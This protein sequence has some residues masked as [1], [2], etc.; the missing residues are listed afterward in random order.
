VPGRK[1]ATAA[2]GCMVETW[3][4]KS[5]S[6]SWSTPRRLR[7]CSVSLTATPSAS[8]RGST[9]TCHALLL[10]SVAAARSSG[11]AQRSN[12]GTPRSWR[13]VGRAQSGLLLD[14]WAS[15]PFPALTNIATTDLALKL[16]Q[17]SWASPLERSSKDSPAGDGLRCPSFD[18]E[19][20]DE[21]VRSKQRRLRGHHGSKDT[22]DRPDEPRA[23]ATS[24][25]RPGHRKLAIPDGAPRADGKG[26]SDRAKRAALWDRSAVLMRG[27]SASRTTR[28]NKSTHVGACDRVGPSV[29]LGKRSSPG[30]AP[31]S[32]L[33]RTKTRASG[34][35]HARDSIA[36]ERQPAI[37]AT[38]R[39]LSS[40]AGQVVGARLHCRFGLAANRRFTRSQRRHR[41]LLKGS[42]DHAVDCA[43][44]SLAIVAAEEVESGVPNASVAARERAA[45]IG[46]AGAPVHPQAAN[47][48]THRSLPHYCPT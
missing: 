1:G 8:T 47:P 38:T 4:E 34:R 20:R 48:S 46:P 21:V 31:T 9:R 43:L 45:T 7:G 39:C 30:S 29:R 36:M 11:F 32:W 37:P 41:I 42:S 10:T 23:T 5:T 16:I 28:S 24:P 18:G 44:F 22:P 40:R 33:L 14:D 25:E 15:V 12:V 19:Y 3:V 27:V 17:I 6:T 13:R 35:S 26:Q 2:Y